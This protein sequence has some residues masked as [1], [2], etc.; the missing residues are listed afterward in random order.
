VLWE[1]Q[2]GDFANGAQ[3]IIDQ[4]V[5]GSEQKWNQRCGLVLLLPHG[6]EG[7]GPEHSS[8]RLERFLTLCAEDNMRVANVS[9]P[10]QYYHL[11]LRQM[12]G[13]VRKPLAVMTPKSL[14]RHPKV[15][16]TLDELAD[17][18]FHPVLDDPAG[19][20][21]A[22]RVVLASGKVAWD[23]IAARE[24]ADRSAVAIVRLEEVYPFPGHA[25]GQVFQRYPQDAEL[26]WV[27]EEPRNMGAWRF[28]R[29][30]FLDGK[31]EGL[32]PHR[33]LRYIGRRER[34]SPAPG[35]HHAFAREQE[36]LVAEA[37]RVGAR[38]KAAV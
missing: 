33:A 34:A 36:A 11:L 27:Q 16:S 5:S 4:F 3:V 12:A 1:A 20:S 6:Q 8:A 31:V 29:E 10:A 17:G 30:Q 2:F 24:K 25:L 37:L 14:L 26:V 13:D 22:R 32:A 7:Q 15:V 28:V 23:L 38:E 19:P 9:T 18:A 35:S 21:G